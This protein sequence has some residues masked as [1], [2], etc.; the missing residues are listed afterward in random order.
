MNAPILTDAAQEAFE[1]SNTPKRVMKAFFGTG[2]NNALED[3]DAETQAS[4]LAM[5]EYHSH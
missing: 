5:L 1:G 2:P 3:Q 4:V